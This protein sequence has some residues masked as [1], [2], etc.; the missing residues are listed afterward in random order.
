MSPDIRFYRG[1]GACA[2][3]PHI[4]LRELQIT[5]I[6]VLMN[7]GPDGYTPD[8]GTGLTKADF[9]RIN[10]KAQVPTL[11]VDGV[12]ITEMPAVLTCIARLGNA[13]DLLGRNAIEQSQVLSW[14]AWLSGTVHAT[15]YGARL[16]P[17][18]YVDDHPEMHVAIKEKG[19]DVVEKSNKLI[20]DKIVGPFALGDEMTV[21]DFN[22]YLYGRW[23]K[24]FGPFRGTLEKDFP[25]FLKITKEIESRNSTKTAVA[26]EKM[27]VMF[28]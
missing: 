26:A 1:N 16:K 25:K 9:L 4:L 20:E 23:I 24:K 3:V 19:S 17:S 8:A 18:R 21:V 14:L 13:T 22:L 11:V 15:G 2:L 6:E 27:E 7:Y 28:Q 5:F 10:P 12:V